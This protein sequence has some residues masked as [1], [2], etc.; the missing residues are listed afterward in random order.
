MLG[1]LTGWMSSKPSLSTEV[2]APIMRNSH[3]FPRTTVSC[4]SGGAYSNTLHGP[5]PRFSVEAR[6]AESM[7]ATTTAICVIVIGTAGGTIRPPLPLA[8]RYLLGCSQLAGRQVQVA[9][10]AGAV[11][12]ACLAR[13][14]V[15][16]LR[17]CSYLQYRS[18][19][20]AR[21]RPGRDYPTSA[22]AVPFEQAER[23]ELVRDQDVEEP[24]AQRAQDGVHL[25]QPAGHAG[26]LGNLDQVGELDPDPAVVDGQLDHPARGVEELAEDVPRH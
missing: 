24:A 21:S 2:S 11:R 4:R 26:H 7:S 10:Q 15:Q 22:A 9:G 3:G 19:G 1:P 20:R 18:A 6:C 14:S 16:P 23:G 8:I 25:V 5:Q 12:P 17:I 13:A